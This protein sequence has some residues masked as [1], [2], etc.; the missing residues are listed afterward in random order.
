MIAV[1]DAGH[2]ADSNRGTGSLIAVAVVIIIA[3]IALAV[4]RFDLGGLRSMI[5]QS[6]ET[7]GGDPRPFNNTAPDPKTDETPGPGGLTRPDEAKYR[8][9]WDT[10]LPER[11]RITRT[12]AGSPI[13]LELRLVPQ[14]IY[15]MGENDQVQANM[16]QREIWLDD[17]YV[18]T[19]EVTNSQYYAF[20]LD[21][22]YSKPQYWSQEGAEYAL[23]SLGLGGSYFIGWQRIEQSGRLRALASPENKVTLEVRESGLVLGQSDVSVLVL[24]N[25]AAWKDYLR[26]DTDTGNVM[27]EFGGSWKNVLPEDLARD[28]RVKDAGL[29]F[30]TNHAGQV[31]LS[32][33]LAT[34]SYQVIAWAYG[35]KER[36]IFARISLSTSSH[37]RAPAMPVVGLSWFEAEA[38]CN[39]LGGKLPTE[40][41]WEKTARGTDARHYPWGMDIPW[42]AKFMGRDGIERV[43]SAMSNINR[44]DVMEVGAMTQDIGPYGHRDLCGNAAEWVRDVYLERPDWAEANPFSR[45]SDKSR[46]TIRGGST[47]DDDPQVCRGYYRRYS[48]PYTRGNHALGFRIVFTPEEA[49]KAAERK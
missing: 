38:F 12:V 10:P 2:M 29:Y 42:G 36:P 20:I 49:L 39:Y 14:G 26:Y 34:D 30:T 31:D 8:R 5:S 15:K 33:A 40:A 16:P 7:Q 27:L 32:S 25:R 22:G 37:M 24:P 41:Q 19:T 3:I 43:G 11:I 45:G 28:Q 35:A 47:N 23:D 44:W 4:F 17:C 13:E 21:G 46:R 18:S 9:N 6:F 48:D 1:E